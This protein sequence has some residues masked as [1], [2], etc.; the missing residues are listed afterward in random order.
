[1]KNGIF[2][3]Q[4]KLQCNGSDTFVGTL[5]GDIIIFEQVLNLRCLVKARPDPF[6]PDSWVEIQHILKLDTQEW[7][8]GSTILVE[9]SHPFLGFK[10]E[11]MMVNAI[12][13]VPRFSSVVLHISTVEQKI[14]VLKWLYSYCNSFTLK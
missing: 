6:Y 11:N 3:W 13:G 8:R 1:V 9:S 2:C 4:S 12:P 5:K 7:L 10:F 14:Y